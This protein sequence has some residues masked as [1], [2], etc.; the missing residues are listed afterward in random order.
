MLRFPYCDP[1]F[2]LPE[3]VQEFHIAKD[4]HWPVR[5]VRIGPVRVVRNFSF[6]PLREVRIPGDPLVDLIV[7]ML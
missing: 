2:G 6:V 4:G 5:W 7:L 3:T 1:S